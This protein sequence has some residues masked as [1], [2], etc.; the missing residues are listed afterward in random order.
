LRPQRNLPILIRGELIE[1]VAFPGFPDL[2]EPG[3][4]GWIRSIERRLPI[5]IKS[6]L[7]PV[8]K[9]G[10]VQGENRDAEL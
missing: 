3:G 6:R 1:R 7:V 8:A 2:L 10:E 4:I 9:G 5:A